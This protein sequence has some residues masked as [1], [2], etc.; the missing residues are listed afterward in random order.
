M[1]VGGCELWLAVSRP[2]AIIARYDLDIVR[3]VASK[4][5]HGTNCP[6]SECI[7]RRTDRVDRGIPGEQA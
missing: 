3:D 2:Q 7:D 5:G 6:D 4:F 1:E